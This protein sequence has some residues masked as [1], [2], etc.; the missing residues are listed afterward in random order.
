MR[1]SETLAC[2]HSN[3]FL[4]LAAFGHAITSSH[5]RVGGGCAVFIG[6][7]T[8]DR[9]RLRLRQPHQTVTARHWPGS[10]CADSALLTMWRY[11][12]FG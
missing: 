10:F 8:G 1:V 2:C 7:I 6:S 9:F 5:V 11:P 3:G 12:F 4:A